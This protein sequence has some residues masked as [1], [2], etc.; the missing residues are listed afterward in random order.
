MEQTG[1]KVKTAILVLTWNN[2][3]DTL[4]CIRSILKNCSLPQQT[5]L[6]IIDNASEKEELERLILSIKKEKISYSIIMEGEMP[7]E[8]ELP[9]LP[10][11][12][13]ILRNSKNFG[14][15]GGNNRGIML[16]LRD[17]SIEYIWI[18]NNDT[19]M[20][21]GAMAE[22][23]K[24]AETNKNYGFIGSVL[25]YHR[26]PEIIQAVGGGRFLPFLGGAIL[27][28]KGEKIT[29]GKFKNLDEKKIIKKINY[30]MG[31]SIL[32]KKETITEIGL[33][34]ETFFLYGDEVDWQLRAI[35]QN[36]RIAVALKSHIYH[37]E[38]KS[39]KRK[40]VTYFYN[41]SR[42]NTILIRKHF[43]PIFIFTVAL[44]QFF[45]GVMTFK[46]KNI[47]FILRGIIDGFR[48]K[49]DLNKI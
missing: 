35:K 36:W 33:M 6:I 28:M 20:E 27:F 14:Y 44:Y 9:S 49:I 43:N 18:L 34:D 12:I 1:S 29:G 2:T 22:M 19:I 23:L 10:S 13:T 11:G 24:V 46:I 31:A 42:S 25:L 7:A 8:I 17:S 32:I 4:D 47:I 5:S 48:T 30:I 45:R 15:A 37:K 40:S 21:A 41:F 39:I 26:D 16:A 3:E 38:S